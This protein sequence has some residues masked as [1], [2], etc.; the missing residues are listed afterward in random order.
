MEYLIQN[1]ADGSIRTND[2]KVPSE[3]TKDNTYCTLSITPNNNGGQSL[4]LTTLP[5]V[6]NYIKHPVFPY[7]N[8]ETPLSLSNI[9]ISDTSE[10]Q[11]RQHTKG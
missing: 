5:I 2:G 1:G 6:P 8:G 9:N 10:P 7:S 3:L 11:P 4:T